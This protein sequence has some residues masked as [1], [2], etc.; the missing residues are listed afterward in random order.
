MQVK[1]FDDAS[2]AMD[3]YESRMIQDDAFP[4][5]ER[6]Q[7]VMRQDRQ[8]ADAVSRALYLSTWLGVDPRK[9]VPKGKQAEWVRA[10]AAYDA[11]QPKARTLYSDVLGFYEKQTERLFGE[12]DARI[13]RLTLNGKDK[14][15]AQDR[16]RQEFERMKSDGPYAPLMRFGDLTVY[17]EPRHPGE[18]PVFAAFESAVEQRSFVDYLKREGYAPKVGVK[19]GEIEKR[20]LP[21]GDFV[22]KMA[23]IIDKTSSCTFKSS[24]SFCICPNFFNFFTIKNNNKCFSTCYSI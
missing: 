22:G 4:I 5:A 9:A 12:L 3:A 2:E 6:W 13:A 16:L 7:D 1:K 23:G 8:Q 11:L 10:K 18:K 21:T 17:A 20:N 19:M 24:P 15:A 14:Q